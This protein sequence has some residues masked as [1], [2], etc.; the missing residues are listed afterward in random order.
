[1]N[2]MLTTLVSNANPMPKK[3]AA[4]APHFLSL[5]QDIVAGSQEQKCRL[6]YVI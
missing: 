1:V 6:K 2:A 5:S 4:E 3:S